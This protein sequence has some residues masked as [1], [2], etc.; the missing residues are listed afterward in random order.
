MNIILGATGQV[1]S[2]IVDR[3]LKQ[4]KPIKAVIHNPK[5][6]DELRHKGA[7]VAVADAFDLHA[8][9][10]AFKDGSAVFVLTPET[11][12]SNDVIGDTQTILD[13]YRAAIESSQI[14]KI[15]GLSSIGAQS[16]AGNL[17]MSAMLERAF[18]GL[19]AQQIFVRPAYFYSN[20]LPYLDPVKEQGLLPT[21]Y[22]VDLKIPMTS[23]VD[24]AEFLADTIVEPIEDSPIYEL[25][26][27]QWY[28]SIDVAET[29]GEILGRKV[30]A[31]QTPRANWEQQLASIGFTQN[32]IEN[33]I[34]MTTAVIDGS[35][36]PEG[37]KI[38]VKTKT[39]LKQYLQPWHT[40]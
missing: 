2:A 22:P 13:N 11:G 8:L 25:E 40:Q 19:Q 34:E 5:K 36:N 32:A 10:S 17:K 33:F 24:V 6:A 35:V 20:W 28:S 1:G 38:S 16:Q 14:E 15:V 18:T 29:M 37:N 23:P 31:R 3:L 30:E 21:F 26:S 12:S 27:P 39:T 4:N 9:H 7:L